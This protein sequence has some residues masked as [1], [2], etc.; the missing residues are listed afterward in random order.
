MITPGR[1]HLIESEGLI[2]LA[3]SMADQLKNGILFSGKGARAGADGSRSIM[4]MS[5]CDPRFALGLQARTIDPIKFR[6]GLMRFTATPSVIV[7]AAGIVRVTV[8][9]V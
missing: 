4:M 1:V 3:Y 2:G 5:R 8:S 6:V 7:T 9:Q